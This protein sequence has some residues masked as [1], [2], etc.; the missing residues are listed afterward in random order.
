MSSSGS[1]ARSGASMS[2]SPRIAASTTTSLR[3]RSGAGTSGSGGTW[4]IRHSEVMSSGTVVVHSRQAL[5]ISSARSH[6][7]AIAPAVSASTG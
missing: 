3:P 1:S 6:G 2:G 4:R 7:H 5:K